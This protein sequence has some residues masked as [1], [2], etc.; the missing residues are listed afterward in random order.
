MQ[1]GDFSQ[2]HFSFR[3]PL[4]SGLFFV[5][6]QLE[7]RFGSLAMKGR[8]Q[9]GRAF[10]TNV[11]QIVSCLPPAGGKREGGRGMRQSSQPDSDDITWGRS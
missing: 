11:K 4:Y 9:D 3:R 8:G 6:P 10:Q 5:R 2:E 1:A 7:L